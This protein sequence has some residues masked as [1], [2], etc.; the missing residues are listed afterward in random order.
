MFKVITGFEIWRQTGVQVPNR[1]AYTKS[2]Y[3]WLF[4]NEIKCYFSF[5]LCY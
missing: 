3:L 2:K 4:R 5:D 1:C